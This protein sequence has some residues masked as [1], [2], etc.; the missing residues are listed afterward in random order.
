MKRFLFTWAVLLT[1]YGV[2]AQN[3]NVTIV[4]EQ[5]PGCFVVVKGR[6][7]Q[8]SDHKSGCWWLAQ[9][10]T[11]SSSSSS[12]KESGA[13]WGKSPYSDS[14]F[15]GLVEGK[16]LTN[17][18]YYELL[19][20]THCDYCG[21]DFTKHSGGCIWQPTPARRN[22]T[23]CVERLHLNLPPR[24]PAHTSGTI[25]LPQRSPLSA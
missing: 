8:A 4:A 7:L 16:P 24:S 11:S 23:R 18:E 22:S 14:N 2:F 20:R 10:L 13:S 9:Q 17:D 1:A 15:F 3:V 6:H 5:C 19:L 21:G 12:S 25:R